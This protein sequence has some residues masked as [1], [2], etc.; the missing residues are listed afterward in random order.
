MERRAI[1]L[2]PLI[3][4]TAMLLLG[5]TSLGYALLPGAPLKLPVAMLIAGAQATLVLG[6]FMN[7]GRSSPLARMAAAGGMVWLGF[8]FLLAFADIATR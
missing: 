3:V 7:L 2:R 5:A 8:L 4:W 1:V 6:A